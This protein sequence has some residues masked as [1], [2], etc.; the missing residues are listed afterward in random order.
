MKLR[1]FLLLLIVAGLSAFVAMSILDKDPVNL[2][3]YGLEGKRTDT[4]ML[5]MLQPDQKQVHVMNI[6][7]DTYHPTPGHDGLGQAKLNATYGFKQG[8]GVEGLRAAVQEIAGVNI[9]YFVE[10]DYDGV[11][12][13]VNALGGVEVDVPFDMVYDDNQAT[14]PLHIDFKAG[15]Q[16]IQGDQAIG[17]LRFRKSN[18]GSIRE[19]D[20]QRIARQQDFLKAA[21][22]K[23]LSWR[24]PLVTAQALKMVKTDLE[25][26]KGVQLAIGMMGTPKESVYFHVI[27]AAKSGRGKD[28]L[29][30][31][32]HDPQKTLTLVQAIQSGSWTPRVD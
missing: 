15:S 32:F 16:T 25:L 20:V 27:P 18:D 21:A 8:G 7:R 3:V 19:G 29:S 24:L 11:A 23:S 6:P 10:V 30:Y 22:G 28:G 13:I 5:V 14:P 17:Y 4:M 1:Y 9:D 2:L 31:Y 12:G 26:V